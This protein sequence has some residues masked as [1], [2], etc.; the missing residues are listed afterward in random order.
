MKGRIEIGEYVRTKE[1][2]IDKVDK[3]IGM[4]KNTVHLENSK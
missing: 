3:I 2:I 1:G 4:I